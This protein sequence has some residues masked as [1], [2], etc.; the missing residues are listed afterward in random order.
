MARYIHCEECSNKLKLSAQKYSEVYVST[1]G[2]PLRILNCDTC[3]KTL[4]PDDTAYAGMLL[5]SV[6]DRNYPGQHPSV[7][8]NEYLK[9]EK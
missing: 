7:W 2:I 5:A 4:T 6:T 9:L 8:A 1:K 3:N